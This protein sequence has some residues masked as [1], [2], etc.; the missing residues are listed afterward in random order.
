MQARCL[1][2]NAHLV[3]PG[4]ERIGAA[5]EIVNGRIH[6]IYGEDQSLPEISTT[7]DAKGEIVAPGFIDIHTHGAA[8]HD[9]CDATPE[10]LPAFAK[11][12]LKEGVTT[13]LPTTL[14]VKEDAL[15][16][17][18]RA[19]TH[20]FENQTYAKV[21]GIHVE[22]PF[23]NPNCTGAQNP[24]YVRPPN[25]AEIQELNS[26]VPIKIVS[27]AVE[28]PDGIELTEA[29]TQQGII[30]SL[31]HTAAT[32]EQFTAAKKA[33]ATHLTHFCNQMTPLHHREIGLVG[34]GLLDDSIRI[35]MICDGI[36]LCPEMIQLAFKV[37]TEERIMM[38]T[39]SIAASGLSDNQRTRLGELEV[40]IQD[41]VAR[42]ESGALAGSTLKLNVAL[43]N[44]QRFTGRPLHDLIRT[45]SL[46][47]AE[48]LQITDL[49][50]IEPGYKADLVIL[51]RDF[52][53]I[54]VFVNG[55]ERLAD[56]D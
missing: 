35:E 49:G 4:L 11:A 42:L 50:K 8:G 44:I 46:N 39:D 9:L 34:A 19:A 1:I 13:F 27:L 55:V 36:H 17:T 23:I 26:I 24:E 38:I 2:K 48:S 47:Q 54:A 52:Q 20:Y 7:Y 45:T 6:A 5:I 28:M 21:P 16:Q 18:F 43:R 29:L 25:L 15:E 41:G 56:L 53:P 37:A 10:T 12:K 40:I 30:T 33:G 22:G 32:F 14:T 31:A 3:S 51:D